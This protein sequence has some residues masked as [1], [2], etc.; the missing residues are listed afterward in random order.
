MKGGKSLADDDRG[1]ISRDTLYPRSL[2]ERD[3]VR[4]RTDTHV[5]TTFV[6]EDVSVRLSF[7]PTRQTLR[8]VVALDVSKPS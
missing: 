5:R 4:T 1:T 8:R 6:R 7:C 3:Y 2:P